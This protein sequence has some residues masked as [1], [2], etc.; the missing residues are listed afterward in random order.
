ML[1]FLSG[2]LTECL[3]KR[4]DDP[5]TLQKVC[6]SLSPFLFLQEQAA[7]GSP[8]PFGSVSKVLSSCRHK[9]KNATSVTGDLPRALITEKMF[10]QHWMRVKDQR[11]RQPF[12]SLT[13]SIMVQMFALTQN[14]YD[15]ISDMAR[16]MLLSGF[17]LFPCTL[18]ARLK[19]ANEL[20]ASPDS[21]KEQLNGVI[22]LL[23][24][25]SVMRKISRSWTRLRYFL[26][27]MVQTHVHDDPIIQG[28]IYALFL[29]FGALYSTIPIGK[30]DVP[31]YGACPSQLHGTVVSQQ[32]YSECVARLEDVAQSSLDHHAAIVDVLLESLADP[33]LHWRY[34]VIDTVLLAFLTCKPYPLSPRV[35]EQFLRGTTS[36]IDKTRKI[37][38]AAVTRC[39]DIL[40]P[41]SVKPA[42]YTARSEA[43]E[44]M[45]H[46]CGLLETKEALVEAHEQ[47]QFYDK[48]FDGYARF[49]AR[50]REDVPDRKAVFLR[51]VQQRQTEAREECERVLDRFCGHVGSVRALVEHL[52]HDHELPDEGDETPQ[53]GGKASAAHALGLG[54]QQGAKELADIHS[55]I[56]FTKG[57]HMRTG[58][59]MR[60][61]VFCIGNA[62]LVKSLFRSVAFS[63]TQEGEGHADALFRSLQEVLP[64]LVSS[65][66]RRD[67]A[68]AAEIVG[69]IIRGV[70]HWPYDA[71]EKAWTF[72]EEVLTPIITVA[73]KVSESCTTEWSSALRFGVY[74]RDPRRFPWLVKLVYGQS[75]TGDS[76]S[77]KQLKKLI[78][79]RGLN[80]EFGW[81]VGRLS[82][83]GRVSVAEQV[84]DRIIPLSHSALQQVR[85][86]VAHMIAKLLFVGSSCWDGEARGSPQ[87]LRLIEEGPDLSG[88]S[89]EM[90]ARKAFSQLRETI[91][92]SFFWLTVCSASEPLRPMMGSVLPFVFNATQDSDHDTSRGA[93]RCLAL[94]AQTPLSRDIAFRTW[95]QSLEMLQ[96]S[97]WHVRAAA[98]PFIQILTFVN[99]FV[100]TDEELERIH[101]EVIASLR[102]VQP[103]VRQLG[104]IALGSLLRGASTTYIQ[105]KVEAFKK[106]ARAKV[107]LR[108][109]EGESDEEHAKRKKKALRRR[110]AGT[111][112]LSAVL[113]LHPYD[114]PRWIA[115][116]LMELLKHEN[117]PAPICTT[118]TRAVQ[119]FTRTHQDTWAEKQYDW[120][121]QEELSLLQDAHS[122]PS[123][124]A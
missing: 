105:E 72:L 81:K 102:D 111:L 14:A 33:T 89:D 99:R 53:R 56:R 27:A 60:S 106:L 68:T 59:M 84:L 41:I 5:Q 13:R 94:L 86:E 10:L 54:V 49:P 74:W 19:E 109:R 117:D 113:S 91:T 58:T 50:L 37:S 62:E 79:M 47:G 76:S 95:S 9:W 35:L 103:E 12:S 7:V 24:S 82:L 123:Y 96:H 23:S 65:E 120:F 73:N 77:V 34:Q 75:L 31:S 39:M 3:E 100:F 40:K 21:T 44:P 46:L 1:A 110:H 32:R 93:K 42:F 124:Y 28:R 70:F 63:G 112:G 83:N 85:E 66:D 6:R 17:R 80:T 20:L 36:P 61:D 52:C 107:N 87:I 78:F 97:N 38:V 92:V 67:Q 22:N 29:H 51:G 4:P 2:L 45:P 104:V 115:D 11:F 26:T 43:R 55:V 122:G 25:Q 116:V 18:A 57:F 90:M 118:V 8:I 15:G 64:R 71:Q 108:Q 16:S 98:L 88:T 114:V 30:P 69:G 48:L 119:E 101:C 121:T